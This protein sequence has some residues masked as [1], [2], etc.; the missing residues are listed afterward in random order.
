MYFAII[1]TAAAARTTGMADIET[2]ADAA[3]AL[4]PAAGSWA[5]YLW[6][7]GILGVGALSIPVLTGS[8]AYAISEAFRF[9]RSLDEG[10]RTAQ[11]FYGIITL[12]TVVAAGL[13]FTGMNPIRALF[14]VELLNGLLLPP[15]ILII[16]FAASNRSVTRD[17]RIPLSLRIIGYGAFILTMLAAAGFIFTLVW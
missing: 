13:A 9:R 1:A 16:V 5:E 6:V 12:A 8:A 14:L 3:R 10:P 15:L 4:E 17:Y 11:G 2:A 7:A